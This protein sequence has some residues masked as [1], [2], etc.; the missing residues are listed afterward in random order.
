MV[1][2]EDDPVAVTQ[3]DSHVLVV[4]AVQ[5]ARR[6]NHEILGGCGSAQICQPVL[7]DF[8]HSCTEFA[9]RVGLA[10]TDSA[11]RLGV[12]GEFQRVNPSG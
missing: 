11:K 1:G 5:F 4:C 6:A 3:V 8:S 12:E 10:L 2:G 7:K 9:L